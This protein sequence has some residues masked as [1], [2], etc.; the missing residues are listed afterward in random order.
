MQIDLLM[1]KDQFAEV[2]PVLLYCG[3]NMISQH[4]TSTPVLFQGLS[5]LRFDNSSVKCY[6]VRTGDQNLIFSPQ[7]Y[8]LRC[9]QIATNKVKSIVGLY[10]GLKE[11]GYIRLMVEKKI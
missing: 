11:N 1:L 2:I 8:A 9:C 6:L 5:M 3:N 10:L 7:L 4:L